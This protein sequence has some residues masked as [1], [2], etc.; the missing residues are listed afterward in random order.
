[1]TTPEGLRAT[2]RTLFNTVEHVI[3]NGGITSATAEAIVRPAGDV[4]STPTG[5][6]VELAILS[7]GGPDIFDQARDEAARKNRRRARD[8]KIR[9]Y[10]Y[11]GKLGDTVITGS[12]DMIKLGIKNVIHVAVHEN[13]SRKVKKHAIKTSVRN[14]LKAADREHLYSVA[15]PT[16][17]AG[18]SYKKGEKG[19]SQTE[20]LRYTLEAMQQYFRRHPFSS[21]THTEVMIYPERLPQELQQSVE[22]TYDFSD[23]RRRLPFPPLPLRLKRE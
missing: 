3:R 16:I 15:F 20:S 11:G 18:V 22:A 19:V 8:S 21:I 13:K 14:V 23:F 4:R 1:M 6:G 10:R 17:G 12:G 2:Q 5:G 7:A 9:N